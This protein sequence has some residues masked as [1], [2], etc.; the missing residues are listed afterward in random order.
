MKAWTDYPINELGDQAGVDAPVRECT[1]IAYDKD[2]YCR[3][4]V[5]G[6]ETEIKAGYLYQRPG[7][8]IEAPPVRLQDLLHLP[9]K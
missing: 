5:G 3:V 7:R 9:L 1:I 6:I 4:R 8:C 2:K